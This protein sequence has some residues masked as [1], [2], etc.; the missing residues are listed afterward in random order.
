[1]ASLRTRARS[2]R[3]QGRRYA[4]LGGAAIAAALVLAAPAGAVVVSG[5]GGVRVGVQPIAASASAQPLA[6][7]PSV[8]DSVVNGPADSG[9]ASYHGGP[10]I[11]GLETYVI[12]WD[13][14]HA[15][16]SNTEAL[17]GRY[18]GDVAHDSGS[19]TNVFSVADQYT[20]AS[21]GASYSQTYGGAFVDTTPYPTSGNCTVGGP[22]TCLY[23]SQEVS[24]LQSFV[25]SHNLPHGLGAMYF[26]LT[27]DTTVTCMDASSQC[28]TNSFCSYHSY[29]GSGAQTLLY[30]AIPFTLL[31][32]AHDAK[33]CQDDGNSAVEAPNADPGFGD[34]A[35]K[36]MSHE[37]M[38]TITDPLL[39]GWYF[40]DGDEIAD[41][42][43]GLVWNPNSFLPSEGGSATAGTLFNQTINADHYYLQASWSNAT[44]SCELMSG[45]EPAI[46]APASAASGAPVAI[47][48]AVAANAPVPASGYS[49][50][51]GDGQT[52]V[53]QAVTH[54]YAAAGTYTITLTATDPN[55]E[56]GS[57][58]SQITIATAA[59]TT[60]GTTA[61]TTGASKPKST[62]KCG[63]VRERHGT[64]TRRCTTTTVSYATRLQ[65]GR[66]SG[67]HHAK[68]ARTCREIWVT[69]TRRQTCT[70]TNASRAEIV[71]TRCAPYRVHR[72]VRVRRARRR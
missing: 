38:E 54:A 26:V 71:S 43:N 2:R 69:T 29:A 62:T 39:S 23:D 65:C 59:V 8:F 4:I 31:D 70:L 9:T 14:S 10:V 12:F 44:Q 42:C 37:E 50:Q 32:N 13:P 67:K 6:A 20:D 55:G 18:L 49:W 11:H 53:G 21:G 68:R 52:A 66:A 57:I 30:A 19:T 61:A 58:T 16:T 22:R 60:H 46:T 41:S 51:F 28:S 27:P 56:T 15:F 45:P 63:R 24:E 17:V 35:I 48:G 64:S 7:S 34:V 33:S 47:S 1:M 5:K 72:T 36:A 25:T 3:S 40:A